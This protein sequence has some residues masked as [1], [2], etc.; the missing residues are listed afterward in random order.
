MYTIGHEVLAP[1]SYYEH[2]DHLEMIVDLA[3]RLHIRLTCDYCRGIGCDGCTYPNEPNPVGQHKK[4]CESDRDIVDDAI[5]CY[6]AGENV[7][8]ERYLNWP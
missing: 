5:A 4:L 7:R 6:S 8:P 3:Y 2:L 1:D